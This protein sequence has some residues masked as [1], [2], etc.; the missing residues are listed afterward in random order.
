MTVEGLFPSLVQ[1]PFWFFALIIGVVVSMDVAVVEITRK[2]KKED[3]NGKSR[4]WTSRMQTMMF[5]HAGFHSVSFFVYMI[6]IY[7]VQNYI[8]FWP[9]DI[10]DLPEDVGLG[11]LTLINFFI[12]AFIWWTY[13]NKVKEDHSEKSDDSKAVDRKDMKFFVDCVRWISHKNHK[14]N[15]GDKV[16]GA[17][18]AGSVAVDM[19]A[20][21]ALLKGVLLPNGGEAPIA[22]WTGIL[23]LDLVVFAFIIFVVV[24]IFVYL[25]QMLGTAAREFHSLVF[26]LRVLEPLAVFFILAGVARLVAGLLFESL[27]DV[28]T[29]YGD[30]VD[31]IFAAVVTLSLFLTN[32]I[33]WQDLK[34]LYAKHSEDWKSSNPPVTTKELWDEVKGFFYAIIFV[35][36]MFPIVFVSMWVAYSTDPGRETHNHLVEATGYIAGVMFVVVVGL[37]YAPFKW[38]DDRET[39]ETK[40]FRE[41]FRAT[42]REFSRRLF[43]IFLALLALNTHTFLILG[44]TIESE[45]IVLWS[46][47]V[48]L[49]WALFDLRRWRFYKS[50]PTGESGRTDDADY[51]ELLT[52]FGLAS[53]VVASAASVFVQQLIG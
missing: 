49:G 37:L 31:L 52:A 30:W 2:Y 44:R 23:F 47:Y 45:S 24:A 28:Y 51:A 39:S 3:R 12:V 34:D 41:M 15:W 4:L 16:A 29:V 10:F 48:M 17:A 27:P 53:S 36:P 5:L 33:C 18:V 19:L 32:G 35:L 9:I 46:V 13:K 21:S 42:P 1:G 8:F 7:L 6:F 26:G 40:N 25:A 14:R 38:L 50:D 43:A 20:V 22:S 11:L